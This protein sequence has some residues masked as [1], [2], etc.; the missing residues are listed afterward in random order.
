MKD[1]LALR[2]NGSAA[3]HWRLRRIVGGRP[4]STFDVSN[5]AKARYLFLIADVAKRTLGQAGMIDS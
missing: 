2:K 5:K 1:Q 3:G 4:A